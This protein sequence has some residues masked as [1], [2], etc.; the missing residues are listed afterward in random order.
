[1]VDA[2]DGVPATGPSIVGVVALDA[3]A[4]AGMAAVTCEQGQD[5]DDHAANSHG[6]PSC[7]SGVNLP[8]L[9]STLDFSRRRLPSQIRLS[10]G[11]PSCSPATLPSHHGNASRSSQQK[12]VRVA[13]GERA[14]PELARRR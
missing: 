8:C 7:R 12:S 9:R 3:A 1:M 13:A 4:P 11:R 2:S 6:S 10:T 5:D 14:Q